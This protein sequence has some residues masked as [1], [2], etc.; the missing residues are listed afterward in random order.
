[1]V[2]KEVGDKVGQA[3]DCEKD[4]ADQRNKEI[5]ICFLPCSFNAFFAKGFDESKVE[6]ADRFEQLFVDPGDER[7]GSSRNARY[8]ICSSHGDAAQADQ[9]VF[10]K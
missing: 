10:L 8:D 3:Y 1:M 9:R 4:P 7:N 2:L 6:S 5:Q